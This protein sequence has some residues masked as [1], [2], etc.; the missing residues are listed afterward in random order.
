[1]PGRRGLDTRVG[2]E[3]TLYLADGTRARSNA[4]LV[5]AARHLSAEAA[6]SR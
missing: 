5:T 3:D 2:L 6:G 4:D 1:M